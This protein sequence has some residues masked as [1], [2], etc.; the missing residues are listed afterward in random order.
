MTFH[1]ELFMSRGRQ[2]FIIPDE[3]AFPDMVKRVRFR[4]E[5]NSVVITPIIPRAKKDRSSSSKS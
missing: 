1:V 3:M 2:A 5:G 4:K